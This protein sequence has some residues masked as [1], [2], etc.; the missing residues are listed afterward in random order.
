MLVLDIET[1]SLIVKETNL[2]SLY[3]SRAIGKLTVYT[4]EYARPLVLDISV[5][6]K[7]NGPEFIGQADLKFPPVYCSPRG[8]YWQFTMP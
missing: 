6:Y 5:S 4:Y 2:I 8:S 7:S 3:N 1:K